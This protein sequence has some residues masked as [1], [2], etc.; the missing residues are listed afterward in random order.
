MT[1]PQKKADMACSK[2]FWNPKFLDHL[3]LK[4]SLVCGGFSWEA[5]LPR[6]GTTTVAGISK[7]DISKALRKGILILIKFDSIW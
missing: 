6:Q 1:W 3:T 4:D 7:E 2:L 5:Q